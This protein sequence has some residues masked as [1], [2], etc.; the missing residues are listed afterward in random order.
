MLTEQELLDRYQ[1]LNQ[2][3]KDAKDKQKDLLNEYEKTLPYKV[4]DLVKIKIG[5]GPFVKIQSV[6]IGAIS[7]SIGS[8]LH[9]NITFNKPKKDGTMGLQSAGI[10][11]YDKEYGIK[12]IK[13]A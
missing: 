10:Y 11:N 4:G 7:V 1:E 9:I 2:V 13:P 5:W 8:Y 3:I 6:Y 12:V